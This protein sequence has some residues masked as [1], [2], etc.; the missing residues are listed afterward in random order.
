MLDDAT[1]HPIEVGLYGRS[2][3]VQT[4]DKNWESRYTATLNL[5]IKKSR[6]HYFQECKIG[7]SNTDHGLYIGRHGSV[8]RAVNRVIVRHCPIGTY[9]VTQL[10]NAYIV[11]FPEILIFHTSILRHV[12]CSMIVKGNCWGCRKYFH[13][14]QRQCKWSGFDSLARD[15]A[16]TRSRRDLF[17][18][19]HLIT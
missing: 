10:I 17:F 2:G 3:L 18:L 7:A 5:G 12:Y 15:I 11:Y 1:D 6:P 4:K 9:R 19:N 8:S 16:S 14:F 13:Y